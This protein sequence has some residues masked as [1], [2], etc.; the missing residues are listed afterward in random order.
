MLGDL[1]GEEVADVLETLDGVTDLAPFLERVPATHFDLDPRALADATVTHARPESPFAPVD[2]VVSLRRNSES[3]RELSS[4]VALD[5]A[6]QMEEQAMESGPDATNEVVLQAD[7]IEAI[8]DNPDYRDQFER[9]ASAGTVDFYRYDD[10]V[11]FL[12]G[13]LDDVVVLGATDD[14]GNPNVLVE[15]DAPAVREW[16]ERVYREYKAAATRYE[17]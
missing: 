9:T 7:V 8:L 6:E 3:I 17:G 1:V 16:A 13:L 14:D 15:S 5:S 11:P 2:R 4:I 12:L 10:R